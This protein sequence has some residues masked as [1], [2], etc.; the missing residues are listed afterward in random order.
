[1]FQIKLL[2]CLLLF[3]L[4]TKTSAQDA[5]LSPEELKAAPWFYSLEDAMEDPEK[6]YNLSITWE[7]L[8]E[9]PPEIFKFV[10]LQHLDLMDN[11]IRTIPP[12]IAQ[13]KN[14][15]ILFLSNNKISSLPEEL[16]QLEHLED[17]HLERNKME[18]LPEWIS[19]VKNLKKIGL[20]ENKI[21]DEAIEAL[22]KKLEHIKVTK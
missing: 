16:K 12:Q 8:K 7:K 13:L 1:M 11:E 10:N 22:D 4:A 19:E 5:L 15:Q 2:T 17:L 14:L 20:R 21:T 6:V 3:V 9:F 18:T